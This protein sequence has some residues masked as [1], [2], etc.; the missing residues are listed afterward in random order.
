MD[1]A[2]TSGGVPFRVNY[3]PLTSPLDTLLSRDERYRLGPLSVFEIYLN[4][5]SPCT[6]M[7]HSVG[8]LRLPNWLNDES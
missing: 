5:A 7:C 8:Y 1:V 4:D 6:I 3:A 2:L